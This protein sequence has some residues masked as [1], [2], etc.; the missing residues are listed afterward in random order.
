MVFLENT[1]L[2]LTENNNKVYRISLS[3]LPQQRPTEKNW[4]FLVS[5]RRRLIQQN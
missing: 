1:V 4:G 3:P 5:W 2:C